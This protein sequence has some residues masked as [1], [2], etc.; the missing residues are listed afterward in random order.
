MPTESST[1]GVSSRSF[2]AVPSS[3]FHSAERVEILGSSPAWPPGSDLFS[4]AFVLG[5]PL[6]S[7]PKPQATTCRCLKAIFALK[8]A[9]DLGWHLYCRGLPE[10][11]RGY[12]GDPDIS[13]SKFARILWSDLLWF[14]GPACWRLDTGFAG[15]PK[16]YLHGRL[17]ES[18]PQM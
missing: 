17:P 6:K 12:Q 11:R 5:F 18:R 14:L 9:W 1:S 16:A 8:C 4:S 2:W 7:S 10:T 3:P 15:T 13:G